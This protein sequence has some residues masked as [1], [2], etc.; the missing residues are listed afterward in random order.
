MVQEGNA[1]HSITQ[2]NHLIVG[3]DES[4]H[5][6]SLSEND[7]QDYSEQFKEPEMIDQSQVQQQHKYTILY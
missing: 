1:I 5:F 3:C 7:I 2:A 4:E 6:T